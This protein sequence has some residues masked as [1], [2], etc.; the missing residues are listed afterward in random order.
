MNADTLP[1][2]AYFHQDLVPGN[3][4]QACECEDRFLRIL[5]QFTRRHSA[6]GD[7]WDLISETKL[8]LCEWIRRNTSPL[9][10]RL[11][12]YKAASTIMSRIVAR[13]LRKKKRAEHQLFEAQELRD[14]RGR[15]P[16]ARFQQEEDFL[17]VLELLQELSHPNEPLDSRQR[18][19]VQDRRAAEVF[20]VRYYGSIFISPGKSETE[21]R[22]LASPREK[23]M[24]LK[25]VAEVCSSEKNPCTVSQAKRAWNR[26]VRLLKEKLGIRE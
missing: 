23:L 16:D 20:Q 17:L 13:R 6:R 4:K 25:D 9:E 5:H 8:Q 19:V 3:E 18:D 11:A 14:P 1:M 10:N 2:T 26:V 22:F 7:T 24:S 15:L 12:Y 21:L